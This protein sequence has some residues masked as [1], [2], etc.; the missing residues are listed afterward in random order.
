MTLVPVASADVWCHFFRFTFRSS[1]VEGESVPGFA[2]L[3]FELHVNR[4]RRDRFTGRADS[5]VL[6]DGKAKII[7]GEISNYNETRHR[8]ERFYEAL[9]SDKLV[10][11]Y[12]K[13]VAQMR[14]FHW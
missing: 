10:G 4:A 2:G 8:R 6:R 1:F 11:A 12:R 13:L 9:E 7:R 5:F 3:D 14:R